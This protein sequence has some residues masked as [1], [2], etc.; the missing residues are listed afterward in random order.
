M[1]LTYRDYEILKLVGA[2]GQLS[3]S[4]LKELIFADR[5]HSVPDTVLKRLDQHDYL[6]I[7]GRRASGPKGGAGA[8][9]YKLGRFGR[10]LLNV[11]RTASPNVNDH[12][13]MVADTYLELRRAESA[14]VLRV[15]DW[16]VERSVP[17][18]V[19]ADLFAAVEYPQQGRMSQYFLEIDRQSEAPKRIREKIAG[20]WLAVEGSKSDYFPFVVFVVKNEARKRELERVFK[21][22]PDD[23]QEMVRVYLLSELIPALMRL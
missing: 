11:N 23:R 17:P 21:Q 8:F 10:S 1:E 7:V 18:L 22:L 4:H 6:S 12:A 19:R 3:S 13:L 9:T 2:F 16:E 15:L 5:S 14:G 20:Y